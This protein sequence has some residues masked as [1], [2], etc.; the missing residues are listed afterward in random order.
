MNKP[1]VIA[2]GKRFGQSIHTIKTGNVDDNYKTKKE[3]VKIAKEAVFATVD[4][5][6]INSLRELDLPGGI[7][8]IAV[9][10]GDKQMTFGL[11][12]KLIESLSEHGDS[13]VRE[14]EKPVFGKYKIACEIANAVN[15]SERAR[16][17]AIREDINKQIDALN[18]I[19]DS[20]E[21]MA[22]LYETEE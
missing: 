12:S 20:N 13:D 3:D 11:D 10:G 21:K 2:L 18:K 5:T 6:R 17:M 8:G 22:P 4:S 16:L 14:L 1:I 15:I 9:N 19:I 7:K